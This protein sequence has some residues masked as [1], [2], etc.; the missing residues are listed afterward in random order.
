MIFTPD[1]HTYTKDDITWFSATYVV[2]CIENSFDNDY[3][4]RYKA[5]EH[6]FFGFIEDDEKR[7]KAFRG[8]R[9]SVGI[10]EIGNY[11]LFDRLEVICDPEQHA[12]LVE[13]I[14]NVWII[15]NKNSQNK[16]SAFHDTQEQ[17]SILRGYEVN[18]WTAEEQPVI[19]SYEWQNNKKISTVD[20]CNLKSGYYPEI[21]VH[22]Q[23]TEKFGVCGQLDRLWISDLFFWIADYKTNEKL[24]FEN[25]FQRLKEPLHHLDDCNYNHYRVQLSVYAWILM[26]YG[27]ILEDMRLNWNHEEYLVKFIPEIEQVII[28]ALKQKMN[29]RTTTAAG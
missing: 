24:H 21:I 12:Q 2:K 28:L 16:G 3:W 13:I 20:I 1:T 17:A 7:K 4:T 9:K 22:K 27:Y 14:N 18:P 6:I 15:K 11:E 5:F 29:E 23:L 8:L 25:K 19:V 10:S 26:E